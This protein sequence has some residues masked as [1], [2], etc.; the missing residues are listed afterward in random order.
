M[1][2]KLDESQLRQ[3][4]DGLASGLSCREI[5]ARL[6]VSAATAI[7][8]AK[9]CG[10]V[11]LRSRRL[12]PERRAALLQAMREGETPAQAAR[13]HNVSARTA[14]RLVDGSAAR[15]RRE[16]RRA[17]LLQDLCSGL[18]LRDAAAAAGVSA[19]TAW[20]WAR[21]AGATVARL[22]RRGRADDER[23]AIAAMEA[24]MNMLEAAT[25]YRLSE[26]T[27]A[28]IGRLPRL[29]PERLARRRRLFAALAAGLSCRK[30][31]AQLDM[32]IATAIR[33]ARERGSPRTEL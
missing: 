28:R 16:G 11:S 22:S 19:S 12:S 31:A 10:L 13:R 32:P 30:A 29:A 23:K 25:T 33:W 21:M 7:R 5:A 6:G 8:W 2:R 17:G 20:R 24:G 26:T 15:L 1:T 14:A 9:R 4:A 18:A 27:M 3:L